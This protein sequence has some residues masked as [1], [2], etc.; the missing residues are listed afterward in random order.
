[1]NRK[2]HILLIL[3]SLL[4]LISSCRKADYHP[5]RTLVPVEDRT[6]VNALFANLRST[7]EFY[8]VT[9][10]ILTEIRASQGTKLR[11]YPYSFKDKNGKVMLSGTVRVGI[12][13]MYGAGAS[14][15]NRSACLSGNQLLTNTGQAY[16]TASVNGEE[17]G[18]TRYGIGFIAP[19]HS[20]MAMGLYYGVDN[21]E[22]SLV[23]W[24]RVGN[25]TGTAVQGTV[26]DTMSVLVVD[27]MGTG[28][29][30]AHI[31][32]HYNQFDSCGA[33][34]WVGSM[35]PVSV[36][37]GLTNISVSPADTSF[38]KTNTAVFVVFPDHHAVV[39]VGDYNLQTHTFS[40]P[41]GYN[42]P[43]ESR[44]A[45]VTIGYKNGTLYFN[46][47]NN[48]TLTAGMVFTPVMEPHTVH[49]VLNLLALL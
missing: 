18:V 19:T 41:A 21:Y 9:A 25:M 39:P 31:Y 32:R 16:I 46:S 47:Q 42:V 49:E 5:G 7:P 37:T 20:A 17:I 26:F 28:V 6:K 13:E 43:L 4:L 22:D 45:I 34:H 44:V 33:L 3:S 30:T 29:D 12:I 14:L 23:R 1:M 27:T 15:A 24:M 36:S 10:G 40:F 48:I 38:N 2:K 11:F 35:Y 8:D